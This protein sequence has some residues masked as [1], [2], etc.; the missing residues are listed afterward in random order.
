[1]LACELVVN[2]NEDLFSV[3]VGGPVPRCSRKFRFSVN[4]L[5]ITISYDIHPVEHQRQLSNFVL[6]YC[7]HLEK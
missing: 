1:M 6:V 7:N 4:L 3:L 5:D 2:V